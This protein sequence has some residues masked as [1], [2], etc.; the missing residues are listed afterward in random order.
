MKFVTSKSI[1]T[2]LVPAARMMATTIDPRGL[3]PNPPKP[4]K[5]KVKGWDRAT[6]T[7]KVWFLM[8][9]YAYNR[10]DLCFMEFHLVPIVMSVVKQSFRLPLLAILNP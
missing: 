8:D 6:F 10:M 2:T 7:I 3:S 1:R 5:P 9:L 4:G